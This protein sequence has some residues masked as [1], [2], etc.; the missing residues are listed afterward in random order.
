MLKDEKVFKE[1]IKR[2]S[3]PETSSE[4]KLI[5]ESVEI[6]RARHESI[7]RLQDE[8][9]RQKAEISKTYLYNYDG[10]RYCELLSILRE[11]DDGAEA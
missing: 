1:L 7:R 6:I 10:G 2:T 9:D 4:R 8:I 11:M 5:F 3:A